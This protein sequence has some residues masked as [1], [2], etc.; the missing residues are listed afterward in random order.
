MMRSRR[1]AWLASLAGC[2]MLAAI[3]CKDAD[4]PRTYYE[5]LGTDGRALLPTSSAWHDT[6]I[7]EGKA[8]W[9]PFRE[10]SD[11]PP[12][13]SGSAAAGAG[14]NAELDAEIRD[15]VD[16]Y[17]ELIGDET[18][19]EILKYYVETQRDAVRPLLE[20]GEKIADSLASLR[21]ELEADL[22][23]A[24]DRIDAAM[25]ALESQ[26]PGSLS[27]GEINS[28]SDT[29]FV[30]KVLRDPVI[31][32]CRF[33]LIDDQWFIDIP[34]VESLA[35]LNPMMDATAAGF[36]TMIQGLESGTIPALTV[37]EQVEAAAAGTGVVPD[38]VD[39]AA[40]PDGEEP[41]GETETDADGTDGD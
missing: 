16:E 31:P 17:N 29:V 1:M 15:L 35:A 2:A 37:L 40:E 12:A 11:E 23:D 22:P 33:R 38:A 8:D 3:G 24:G 41:P 13:P 32:T 6:A 30:A 39:A 19:D 20:A 9:H 28:E 27:I 14:V 7:A 10:P 36:A 4:P 34:N 25:K 18:V 21:E 5:D 26:K